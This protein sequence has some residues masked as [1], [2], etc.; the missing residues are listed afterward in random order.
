LADARNSLQNS[1][2]AAYVDNLNAIQ[3]SADTLKQKLEDIW[4]D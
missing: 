3:K 4:K 1:D 2:K